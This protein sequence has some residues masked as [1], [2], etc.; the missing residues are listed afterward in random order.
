MMPTQLSSWLMFQNAATHL[1]EVEIV[2]KEA[3]GLHRYCYR[4]FSRRAQQLMHALDGLGIAPGER[5]ATLAW[6]HHR[7]LECYFA[8]PCTERARFTPR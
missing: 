4:D 6:N 1:G 2:S 5:V 7:P 3:G 8:I